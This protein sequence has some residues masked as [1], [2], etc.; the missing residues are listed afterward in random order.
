VSRS[1]TTPTSRAP[2]R[3]TMTM[4]VVTPLRPPLQK[5][6]PSPDTA[7][8]PTIPLLILQAPC[9]S[10]IQSPPAPHPSGL[11]LQALQVPA[12]ASNLLVQHTSLLLW[13]ESPTAM[14]LPPTMTL[15]TRSTRTP[16]LL[17]TSQQRISRIY[18]IMPHNSLPWTMAARPV[19]CWL[20]ARRQ[21]LLTL[22]APHPCP[23]LHSTLWQY[24]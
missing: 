14:C 3:T 13:H 22:A 17:G 24:T 21:S 11:K 20:M 2:R 18:M 6:H 16:M 8:G 4:S 10:C 9:T 15:A 1:P 23:S 7:T 12:S 19:L 5:F